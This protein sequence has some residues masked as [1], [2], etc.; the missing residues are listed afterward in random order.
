MR[1][2]KAA[3]YAVILAFDVKVNADAK[4]E[5]KNLG[6]H[7]FTAD[8]IYHLFDQFQVHLEKTGKSKKPEH[9]A[10]FP[11]ILEVE[12]PTTVHKSESSLV[13]CHVTHG[14]LRLDTPLCNFVEDQE[15][16]VHIG[17]VCEILKDRAPTQVAHVGDRICVKLLQ[18]APNEDDLD[19]ERYFR[20]CSSVTRESNDTLK[21]FF[22]N[23]LGHSD[24][25]CL[26]MLKRSLKLA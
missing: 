1:E 8:I 22:H 23:E 6:V 11:V 16:V 19:L 17:W 14:H 10:I 7:I 9:P 5:A 2:K 21:E 12:K 13:Q 4:K 15:K 24:W 18:K 3:E 26:E 25:A 20:M